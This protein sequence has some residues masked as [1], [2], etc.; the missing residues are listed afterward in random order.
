[1]GASFA[2]TSP[3]PA[4]GTGDTIARII[5]ERQ[6]A[7]STGRGTSALAEAAVDRLDVACRALVPDDAGSHLVHHVTDGGAPV[8]VHQDERPAPAAPEAGAPPGQVRD[9]L[10]HGQPVADAEA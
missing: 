9:R 4:V 10:R 8:E 2:R 5:R 3:H 7:I 6:L 1:M